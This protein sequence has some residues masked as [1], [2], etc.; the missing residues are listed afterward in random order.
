MNFLT[1]FIHRIDIAIWCLVLLFFVVFAGFNSGDIGMALLGS[2]GVVIIMTLIGVSI[3][4]IIDTLKNTRG[5][6]TILGFITNGPEL[7]VLVVGIAVA[8]PLFG[9]STPLGSNVFNP[10]ML[11]AAAIIMGK[12]LSVLKKNT[13]Y[14]AVCV[15]FTVSLALGF[16]I[17]PEQAFPIWVVLGAVVTSALFF[18][19]PEDVFEEEGEEEAPKWF[20]LPALT[21]LI[22]AGYLLDP[23]VEFSGQVAN[24]PKG[25]IGFVALAT[26]SSWPEFKSCLTLF[27]RNRVGAAGINIFVSNLTNIWLALIGVSTYLIFF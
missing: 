14:G 12:F 13:F 22:M 2:L 19:R 20:L 21:T 25:T 1:Q 26:L 17:I 9:A 4:V 10:I 23:V 16:Y 7:V 8:D 18:L 27:R 6:G 11:I 5:L 24:V 15:I 3:E